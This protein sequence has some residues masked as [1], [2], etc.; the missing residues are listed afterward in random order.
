MKR[1]LVPVLFAA[2]VVPAPLLADDLEACREKLKNYFMAM[3]VTHDLY[4]DEQND[5]AEHA[6]GKGYRGSLI[7]CRAAI[8]EI[9]RI[10]DE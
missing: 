1:I 4:T 2:F 5:R 8:A 9:D 7:D 3:T 6:F 10:I